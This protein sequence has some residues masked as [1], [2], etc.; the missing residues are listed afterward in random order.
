MNLSGLTLTFPYFWYPNI[1][2][3]GYMNT[4]EY[5]INLIKLYELILDLGGIE[6][7]NKQILLHLTIGAP[8]EEL[9]STS[10]EHYNHHQWIQLYPNHIS[11]CVLNDIQVIHIIV[12][13]NN[14][15]STDVDYKDPTFIRNTSYLQWKKE[16]ICY[17]STTKNIKIYI[18]YTMFPTVDHRNKNIVKVCEQKFIN[19]GKTFTDA[20]VDQYLLSTYIQT[21]YD[22]EFTKLFY[23]ALKNTIIKVRERG[24]FTTCFSFAVF[25]NDMHKYLGQNY[26]MFKEILHIFDSIKD[27]ECGILAEWNFKLSKYRVRE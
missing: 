12:A 25:A 23:S 5:N 21:D 7:E 13:P 9:I 6:Y 24:G 20:V 26:G 14:M 4:K 15:L 16:G 1:P 27:L 11:E 22:T 10:E 8:A 3:G 18:F 19:L 2:F 17:T